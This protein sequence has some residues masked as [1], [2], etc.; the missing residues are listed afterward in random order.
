[1]KAEDSFI[2]SVLNAQKKSDKREISL[3]L[4]L[5]TVLATFT[6]HGSSINN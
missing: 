2:Q 1:M 6:A 4:P 3:S 5:L